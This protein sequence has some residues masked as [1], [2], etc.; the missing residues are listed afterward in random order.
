MVFINKSLIGEIMM[1]ICSATGN[2]VCVN[3]HRIP[4]KI[5]NYSYGD[6]CRNDVED[7]LAALEY[8]NIVCY[9]PDTGRFYEK[10][11]YTPPGCYID[12]EWG[13]IG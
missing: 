1:K 11:M 9:N 8:G 13:V 7:I 6:I 10:I 12:D 2:G 4:P 5:N 3:C